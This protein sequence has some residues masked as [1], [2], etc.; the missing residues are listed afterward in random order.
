MGWIFDGDHEGYVASR[1]TPAGV[2]VHER[3]GERPHEVGFPVNRG[4]DG[5]GYTSRSSTRLAPH[6]DAWRAACVCG[7]F[8]AT[9]HPRRPGEDADEPPAVE[10]ACHA[11][12]KTH[13]EPLH[14]VVEIQEAATRAA[15]ARVELNEA[16]QAGRSAGLSWA[17][18][19]KAV[20]TTRQAARERWG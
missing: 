4:P 11:E 15:A 19:G 10:D 7:W 13:V 14:A 18:I 9:V 20:G 5:R 16:V 2:D 6:V 17:D 12:W 3:D 8:G 1:L